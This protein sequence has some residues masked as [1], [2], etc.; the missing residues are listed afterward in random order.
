MLSTTLPKV[1]S[2]KDA[3]IL[4][5]GGK[6]PLSAKEIH[7]EI[8]KSI[9]NDSS[10]QATHKTIN[11]L[12][13]EKILAKS[14]KNYELSQEWINRL[15][16]FSTG[17]SEK[18]SNKGNQEITPD[19]EGTVKWHFDDLSV[20]SLEMLKL[21]T[22]IGKWNNVKECGVALLRHPWFPFN[23]KFIDFAVF[24]DMLKLTKGGYVVL[25]Y[26]APFDRWVTKQYLGS[27][28]TDV[29]LGVKDLNLEHDILIFNNTII[30]A[31]FSDETRQLQDEVYSKVHDLGDLLQEFV[32]QRHTNTKVEIEVQITKNPALSKTMRDQLVEKYF[33]EKK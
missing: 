1:S 12:V 27:G 29:K 3:V 32:F 2:A 9:G 31:S 18:Y 11:Q 30:Q 8:Q 5:L 20:F 13:K 14:G 10:Y 21:L 22:N 19:F 28:V 6:W 4:A 26:D 24:I 16:N 17:L 7:G 33:G 25:Q 15:K 23:F